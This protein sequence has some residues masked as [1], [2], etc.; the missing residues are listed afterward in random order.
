VIA[1][2]CGGGRCGGDLAEPG[3]PRLA[4]WFAPGGG[5]DG[6]AV[7]GGFMGGGRRAPGGGLDGGLINGPDGPGGPSGPPPLALI[8]KGRG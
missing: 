4:L 5:L 6:G 8:E 1:T 7:P 2:F 3:G